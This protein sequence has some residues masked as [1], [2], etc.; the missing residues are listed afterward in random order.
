M[1]EQRKF[2]DDHNE[3][4]KEAIEAMHKT[5]EQF[6]KVD[7]VL[8]IQVI[9]T[10]NLAA[11]NYV[12]F[13]AKLINSATVFELAASSRSALPIIIYGENHHFDEETELTDLIKQNQVQ[14]YSLTVQI[15]DTKTHNQ[16]K[17]PQDAKAKCNLR[18]ELLWN[19]QL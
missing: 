8:R 6:E 10:Q 18:L 2:S 3:Q 14:M 9:E 7:A 12:T 16:E 19:T 15:Y 4:Y 17:E 1:E 11:Q 5:N 13:L